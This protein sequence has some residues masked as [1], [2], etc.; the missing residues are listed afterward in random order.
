MTLDRPCRCDPAANFISSRCTLYLDDCKLY[1]IK[2]A[3]MV[4]KVSSKFCL[5]CSV[6]QENSLCQLPSLL[7]PPGFDRLFYALISKYEVLR[8]CVSHFVASKFLRHQPSGRL[9]V[10][11]A[12]QTFASSRGEA[13]TIRKGGA[14]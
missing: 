4:F 5:L 6:E 11:A 9:V 3:T 12:K 7:F 14:Y 10:A 2:L 1:N 8:D 13:T